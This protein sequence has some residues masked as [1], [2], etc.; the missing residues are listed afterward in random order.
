MLLTV[1][2]LHFVGDELRS[3]LDVKEGGL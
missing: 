3:H 1:L 2:S